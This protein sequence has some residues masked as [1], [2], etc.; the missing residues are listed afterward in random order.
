LRSSNVE[1]VNGILASNVA[2][3]FSGMLSNIDCI[4]WEWG[5]CP[6]SWA[7]MYSGHKGKPSIIWEALATKDLRIWHAYFRMSGSHN[8]I[9]VLQH[10]PVFQDLANG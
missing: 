8:D 1:E 4:H 7:G 9:N 3:G 10:S 5:N 2:K 6:A